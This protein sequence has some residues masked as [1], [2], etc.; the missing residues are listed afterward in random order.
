MHTM[1]YSPSKGGFYSSVI[2]AGAVPG[3]AVVI[4]DEQ[5]R[6]FLAGISAGQAVVVDDEGHATLVDSD[7]DSRALE[8]AWR[9]GELLRVSW[10]RDRHRDESDLQM[11]TTLT[12]DQFAELLTYMQLLRDW[13]QAGVFPA[14]DL[15]PVP[16]PWIDEQS[17]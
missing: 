13:P 17:Q 8:R 9:D 15:R 2:H 12:A 7:V 1:F 11:Q 16:P 5:H 10:L 4:T 3:D 6:A 14:P